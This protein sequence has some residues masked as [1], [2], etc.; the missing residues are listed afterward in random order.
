V[1]RGA[2]FYRKG[3]WDAVIND[4][5]QAIALNPRLVQAWNN[6]GVAR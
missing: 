3:D 5:T 4:N 6:R 1:D 2:L